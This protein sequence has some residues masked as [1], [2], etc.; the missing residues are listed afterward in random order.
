MVEGGTGFDQVRAQLQR[1][2]DQ[3][4]QAILVNKVLGEYVA[5][6]VAQLR[7]QQEG[8]LAPAGSILLKGELAALWSGGG[9]NIS[10]CR[11][12]AEQCLQ[13]SN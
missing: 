13:A 7:A 11:A 9:P 2:R 5:E 4:C 8:N 10:A 6:S 3:F 12:S 1:A